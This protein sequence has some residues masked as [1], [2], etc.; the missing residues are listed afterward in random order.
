MWPA[1]EP[2]WFGREWRSLR[3]RLEADG[4]HWTL[5][6]DWYRRAIRG[7][8]SIF[9]LAPEG[10]KAVADRLVAVKEEF[11][12]QPAETVNR[13]IAAWIDEERKKA[14]KVVVPPQTPAAIEPEWRDG[15]L[16]LVAAPA[17]SD[18]AGG[19]I[20]AALAGLKAALGQLS[21]D[22]A[23]E[24]NI[25]RR[26]K[27]WFARL[28]DRIPASVPSQDVL[29]TVAHNG[30]VLSGY[31]AT[32]NAEWERTLAARLAALALQF[33]RT[34]DKFPEWRAFK[35]AAPT[36]E[37]DAKAVSEARELVGEAAAQLAAPEMAPAIDPVVPQGLEQ[38]AQAVP[39]VQPDPAGRLV[40]TPEA[41]SRAWDALQSLGNVLKRLAEAALWTAGKGKDF[42]Q[43]NWEHFSKDLPSNYAAE[44]KKTSKWSVE[45]LFK[46]LRFGVRAAAIGGGVGLAEVLAAKFPTI[47]GWLTQVLDILT[48]TIAG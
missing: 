41:E 4:D 38:V 27:E 8:R 20:G 15:R 17:A 22:I 48:K 30:D 33:G 24:S 12:R 16:T 37:L 42:V 11:W 44:L 34:F 1:G 7:S 46:A 14:I 13:Q 40:V 25:D 43:F 19:D 47:F 23:G 36:G 35:R 32:A 28:V 2:D 31:L 26:F 10:D 29:F 6:I 39:E 9:G 3:Q 5:W 45:F 18:F 21:A